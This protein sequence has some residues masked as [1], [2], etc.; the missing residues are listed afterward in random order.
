MEMDVRLLTLTDRIYYQFILSH[1][2][3]ISIEVYYD[4]LTIHLNG[5]LVV[6]L[7]NCTLFE[8]GNEIVKVAFSPVAKEDLVYLR[9]DLCHN[10]DSYRKKYK[11][12]L[13]PRSEQCVKAIISFLGERD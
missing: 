4:S 3:A 10:F 9:D 7:S 11:L 6:K 8:R 5:N 13:D 1:S 2:K 12:N